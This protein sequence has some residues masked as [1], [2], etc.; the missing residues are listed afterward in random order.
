MIK[1][2]NEQ[3]KAEFDYID[4][5][6]VFII[7]AF[8]G[9]ISAN[10]P[11]YSITVTHILRTQEEQDRIYGNNPEYQKKKWTSVHQVG[12]GIDVS[13][14]GWQRK[15]IDT[16]LEFLNI[17]HYGKGTLRTTIFHDV[18]RGEHIHIQVNGAG[19]TELVRRP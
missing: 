16:I 15:D 10:F 11:E 1:F 5:R 19:I 6:L 13:T 9:Y 18:G 7:Y 17:A 4:D 2:R 14:A 12:R 8:D 3:D